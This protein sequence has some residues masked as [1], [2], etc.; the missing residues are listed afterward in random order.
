MTQN[1][2][3][4]G[5]HQLGSRSFKMVGKQKLSQ[6]ETT[7]KLG[8]LHWVAGKP[9]AETYRMGKTSRVIRCFMA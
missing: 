9:G 3:N 2:S 4:N 7:T 8:A 1:K 6:D 5:A